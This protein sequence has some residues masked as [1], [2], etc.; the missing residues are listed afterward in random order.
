MK[1][2]VILVVSLLVVFFASCKKTDTNP[3]NEP[4]FV[5]DQ[6]TALKNV[7]DRVYIDSKD[8][9]G[10]KDAVTFQDEERNEYYDD[11]GRWTVDRYFVNTTYF[12]IK[13]RD[14]WGWTLNV[15]YASNYKMKYQIRAD[16]YA[17]IEEALKDTHHIY[18]YKQMVSGKYNRF[19]YGMEITGIVK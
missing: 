11:Y 9:L 13:S 17:S 5:E 4:N 7:N 1:T 8:L 3:F 15:E 6:P 18:C 16:V 19:G 2:K 10:S 12:T 14:Y